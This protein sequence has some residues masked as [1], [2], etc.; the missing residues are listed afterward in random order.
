R[1][2]PDPRGQ[3]RVER[4]LSRGG[5]GVDGRARTW[6][7]QAR[8]PPGRRASRARVHGFTRGAGVAEEVAVSVGST[9]ARAQMTAADIDAVY[10]V[11]DDTR[12]NFLIT[13]AY[14]R[15]STD[16]KRLIGPHGS[17]CTFST[18]SSRTIGYFIRGDIDPV[19]EHWL[20]GLPAWIRFV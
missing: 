1:P 8:R 6:A 13:D 18:W 15:L 3:P 11:V 7:R 16:M 17:W 12:R 19:T 2:R 4:R 9:E 10:R 14:H 20:A 5:T